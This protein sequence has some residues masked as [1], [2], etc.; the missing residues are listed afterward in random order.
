VQNSLKTLFLK[1][2]NMFSDLHQPEQVIEQKR[3]SME[4]KRAY[5]GTFRY[6]SNN[7]AKKRLSHSVILELAVQLITFLGSHGVSIG[8]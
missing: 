2:E 8:F 6:Q 3:E 5:I 7:V 4:R 1:G